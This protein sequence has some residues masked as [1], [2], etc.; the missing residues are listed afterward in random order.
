[1][2]EDLDGRIE[3]I[4]TGG[5]AE[6]GLES[7]VVDCSGR[8]PLLL[9]PGAISLE[10]LRRV[11][12]AIRRYVPR[13]GEAVRS[14]GL[15]H[16]HYAPRASVVLVASPKEAVSAP[17]AAFIGLHRVTKS[18]FARVL[19][20]RDAADYAHNVFRFFRA[21]DAEEL[22]TIYCERVPESGLG[23]A[24]MDRLCRAAAR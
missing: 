14:P 16:R 19:K 20:C 8:V 10:Q 23:V 2:R 7:T 17:D 21:C 11:L 1:M 12:P 15:K 18:S 13:T 6:V 9:R 22:R 5:A 4:L 24:L 3:G